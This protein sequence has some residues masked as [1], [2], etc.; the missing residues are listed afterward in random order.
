MPVL[1]KI[2]AVL[3]LIFMS[4]FLFIVYSILAFQFMGCDEGIVPRTGESCE[5]ADFQIT[6]TP[7]KII[8]APGSYQTIV[9]NAKIYPL[10]PRSCDDLMRKFKIEITGNNPTSIT[11]WGCNLEDL[12][13]NSCDCDLDISIPGGTPDGSYTI[14]LLGTAT[15]SDGRTSVDDKPLTVVVDS[16]IEDPFSIQIGPPSSVSIEQGTSRIVDVGIFRTS[17]LDPIELSIEGTP[18]GVQGQFDPNPVTSIDPTTSSNLNIAVNQYVQVGS[19]DLIIKGNSCELE[20]TV[21]L[22]LIVTSP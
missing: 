16:Q 12:L 9:V 6:L 2:P 1:K 10:D 14:N 21:I 18:S 13:Y 17:C 19:Y 4:I 15:L 20:Q 8:V 7:N 3:S 11:V 22:E 5:I